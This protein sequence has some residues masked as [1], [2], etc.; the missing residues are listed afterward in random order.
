[1]T[2]EG[3]ERTIQQLPIA[4]NDLREAD[5]QW[6]QVEIRTADTLFPPLLQVIRTALYWRAVLQE[7]PSTRRAIRARE[8]RRACLSGLLC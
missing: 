3:I 7:F 2:E 6:R 5:L 8:R 4:V 1:M